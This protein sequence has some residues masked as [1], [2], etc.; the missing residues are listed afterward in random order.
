[1]GI[2]AG[3]TCLD[4]SAKAPDVGDAGYVGYPSLADS[5][6]PA[7]GIHTFGHIYRGFR[8]IRLL[9]RILEDV[10]AFLYTHRGHRLDLW[11]EGD[12]EDYEDEEATDGRAGHEPSEKAKRGRE[13]PEPP[14]TGD[15][16]SGFYVLKCTCG[17]R[18]SASA[19]AAIRSFAP[20]IVT[21]A[22]AQEFH[23]RVARGGIEDFHRVCDP[24]L[25]PED[26]PA[27]F[28]QFLW[29][30]VPHGVTAEVET[31][32]EWSAVEPSD[33]RKGVSS[34]VFAASGC[35]GPGARPHLTLMP[36]LRPLWSFDE[37]VHCAPVALDDGV[38]TGSPNRRETVCLDLEGAVRWR[39]AA[40][41]QVLTTAA[42]IVMVAWRGSKKAPYEVI[43]LD[44]ASGEVRQRERTVY[45]LEHALDDGHRFLARRSF[46]VGTDKFGGEAVA[47]VRMGERGL[48]VIWEVEHRRP[49]D[50]WEEGIG[51]A[52]VDGQTVFAEI[53]Q[54][55]VALNIEN[56]QERWSQRLIEFGGIA[57]ASKAPRP[58]LAKDVIVVATAARRLV[59]FSAR[60][61]RLLWKQ[62]D[63]RQH[64]G[65]YDYAYDHAVYGNTLYRWSNCNVIG[66]FDTAFSLVD[67]HTGR[68]NGH[69]SL[70][71][72]VCSPA[73]VPRAHMSTTAVI[74]EATMFF[75][76]TAGRLWAVEKDT[77]RPLWRSRPNGIVWPPSEVPSVL[78]RRIY[79]ASPSSP[80]APGRL[81]CYEE[82]PTLP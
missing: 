11:I 79:F 44:R 39:A 41:G 82:T 18:C 8:A 81:Y 59:A 52:A 55:F 22:A 10:Y 68:L 40:G 70:A 9:P 77:G 28:D 76:D 3:I 15:F 20:F 12:E 69:W 51:P 19:P 35:I 29:H 48:S 30:H 14:S 78:G 7:T 56:G 72:Q 23:D 42:E 21:D 33:A 24:L 58:A 57:G 37:P 17:E 2:A 63:A 34:M 1:M 80:E 43:R 27:R 65:F 45:G 73:G 50:T 54:R 66:K 53:G 13:E 36:P 47:L 6:D 26:D 61:G 74:A 46:A 31:G 75:G 60:D 62:H 64:G 16:S 25:E 49:P 71:E 32:D 38:L 4:C 5:V 67:V